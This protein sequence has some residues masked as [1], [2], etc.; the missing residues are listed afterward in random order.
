MVFS[1]LPIIGGEPLEHETRDLLL[2][3]GEAGARERLVHEPGEVDVHGRDLVQHLAERLGGERLLQEKGGA[4][5]QG[6]LE[7]LRVG[8]GG[9]QHDRRADLLLAQRADQLD[10]GEL[11]F[12]EDHVGDDRLDVAEIG[13][14]QRA[15]HA[16]VG[17][18]IPTECLEAAGQ[19]GTR[20]GLVFHQ[21]DDARRSPGDGFD[22]IG[23]HLL[24]NKPQAG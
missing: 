3:A 6:R 19:D 2:L 5:V 8:E 17:E 7:P 16:G 14:V 13:I 24:G 20:I 10:A 15:L 18:A 12:A 21:Q 1:L 9:D 22:A 23:D 4:R 11:A